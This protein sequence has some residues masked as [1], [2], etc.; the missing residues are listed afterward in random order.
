MVSINLNT[1]STNLLHENKNKQMDT[2]AF[3]FQE[4]DKKNR[5][6]SL[7]MFWHFLFFNLSRA[8]CHLFVFRNYKFFWN[9]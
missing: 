1:A 5:L 8:V 9:I 3:D 7:F 6:S 4:K 2:D